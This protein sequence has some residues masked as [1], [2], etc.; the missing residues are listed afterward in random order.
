MVGGLTRNNT[1]TVYVGDL[2]VSVCSSHRGQEYGRISTVVGATN[3]DTQDDWLA[4]YLL[5]RNDV[6]DT[7]V[8]IDHNQ[9]RRLVMPME[10][11]VLFPHPI[12]CPCFGMCA[13]GRYRR[14]IFPS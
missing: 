10:P 1:V 9:N 3:N 11:T 6:A 13:S 4:W 12:P 7:T 14:V 8:G 2:S 5:Q